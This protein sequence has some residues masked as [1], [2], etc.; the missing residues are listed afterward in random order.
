MYELKH[1]TIY[2]YSYEEHISDR[3]AERSFTALGYTPPKTKEELSAPIKEYTRNSG[4]L[5]KNEV[6]SCFTV[7]DVQ[8]FEIHY[9]LF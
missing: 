6:K 8:F 4:T 2:I 5:T 9:E 3:D 7:K 1:K